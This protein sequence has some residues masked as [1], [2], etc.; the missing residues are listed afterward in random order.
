M[1]VTV[2]EYVNKLGMRD[3]GKRNV[4]VSPQW[5]SPYHLIDTVTLPCTGPSWKTL[6]GL[7][8]TIG[9]NAGK[10]SREAVWEKL[11]GRGTIL[12]KKKSS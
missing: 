11:A 6:M 3:E 1:T 9:F 10:H 7:Y 2:R 8:G 5:V 4:L 12:K